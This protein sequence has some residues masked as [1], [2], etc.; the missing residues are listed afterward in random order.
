MGW[1][2][3]FMLQ[4]FLLEKST[5]LNRK[6]ILTAG[7]TRDSVLRTMKSDYQNNGIVNLD[8]KENDLLKGEAKPLP[9]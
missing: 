3:G 1:P 8:Q 9:C 2:A 4:L 5:C 7:L 6:S